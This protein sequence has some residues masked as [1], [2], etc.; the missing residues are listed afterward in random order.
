MATS[1]QGEKFDLKH[2]EL[3]GHCRITAE[4]AKTASRQLLRLKD[5]QVD[6]W[7]RQSADLILR[8]AAQILEANQEDIGKKDEF[9]MTAAQVDRLMLNPERITGIAKSLRS[10]AELDSPV[11]EILESQTRPNGLLVNKIRV[12]LG[13]LFFVYESR[14][15]VTADA[16][17]IAVKSRNSIVLRGGK[18]A[19]G[20]SRA[21]IEL[22]SECGKQN[23]IPEDSVQLVQTSDRK[24]VDHFLHFEDLIDLAIPR[25][26]PSLIR[27][28]VDQAKMPVLKHFSGNCHVFVDEHADTK[29]A[30]DIIMNSKCQRLGVCNAAES[31]LVHEKIAGEFLPEIL[32]QFKAGGVEVR[33]DEQVCL[34]DN[35]VALA[36]P[37]DFS[38]EFLDA[39]IS[40]AVVSDVQDAVD[41]VNRFGS[42]HT[43]CIVSQSEESIALFTQQVDSAVVM[44]NA[45]TRFN[46]GGELG[47]GAEIGI[48]T[49]KFHAR[50]PCGLRELTTYKWVCTGDGHIR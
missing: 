39:M 15:N 29:K 2:S 8:N 21:I 1:G 41:H 36:T 31:L 3:K 13:V 9:G 46:D 7:L 20:S 18:E 40:V 47:L 35:R 22:L 28:V 43:D 45:S 12:P 42:G 10:I 4:K 5:S 6:Q 38:A 25:G 44:V 50:G 49:D 33:G 34:V 11:G 26:G 17:A 14:P 32:M 24:V 48:S 16:A 37:E 27:R 19:M 23:G 30:C